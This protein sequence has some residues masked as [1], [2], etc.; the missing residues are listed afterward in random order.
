M[1]N[2][3]CFQFAL[4]LC[5]LDDNGVQIEVAFENH[6]AFQHRIASRLQLDF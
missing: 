4:V 2:A 3:Q 6:E 5:R 1:F